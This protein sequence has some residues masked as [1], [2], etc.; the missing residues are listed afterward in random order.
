MI[1]QE[2]EMAVGLNYCMQKLGERENHNV[3]KELLK[4]PL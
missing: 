1:V 2:S 3:V 4:D